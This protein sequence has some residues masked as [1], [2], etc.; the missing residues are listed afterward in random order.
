MGPPYL[1]GFVGFPG[2][3]FMGIFLV[4]KSVEAM[5]NKQTRITESMTVNSCLTQTTGTNKLQ[6]VHKNTGFIPL[7]GI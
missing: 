5:I 6:P 1:N 3:Y 2:P 4:A 7:Y